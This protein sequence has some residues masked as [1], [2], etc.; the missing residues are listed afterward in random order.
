MELSFIYSIIVPITEAF[1]NFDLNTSRY[2][3]L[4]LIDAIAALGL[5]GVFFLFRGVALYCMAKKRGLR[6]KWM[7]FVPFAN[8]LLTGRLAGETTFFGQRI[9]RAGL[10]AMLLQIAVTMIALSYMFADVYLHQS[11][12]VDYQPIEESL[13]QFSAHFQGGTRF[14]KLLYT[15]AYEVSYLLDMIFGLMGKVLMLVLLSALF[16]QYSPEKH[17]WMTVVTLF[18]PPAYCIII[19]VFR[20][21]KPV[22]YQAYMQ[23]K[24]EAYFRRQQQWYGQGGYNPYGGSPYGYG[25]PTPPNRPQ[26]E[27]FTEFSSCKKEESPFDE[28]S[29]EDKKK[30]DG[31]TDEFFN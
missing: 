4:L 23:A 19:F 31:D 18:V 13:G 27:Q 16:K 11:G 3:N 6:R 17:T 26:E 14:E 15:Y 21:R 29:S 30:N 28:F 25:Q 1:G 9:K 5:A 24:R 2:A 22:N 7:A 12:C 20:N 8:I 10:Y